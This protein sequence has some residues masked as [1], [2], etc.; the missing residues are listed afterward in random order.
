MVWMFCAF[1]CSNIILTDSLLVA[2]VCCEYKYC[3]VRTD[4]RCTQEGDMYYVRSL[5][6]GCMVC[7]C[8]GSVFHLYSKCAPCNRCPWGKTL[9]HT[10]SLVMANVIRVW[11]RKRRG[12]LS[13]HSFQVHGDVVL[14]H[15]R[16]PLISLFANTIAVGR[17]SCKQVLANAVMVV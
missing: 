10:Q 8:F 9:V 7:A 2:S 11:K 14:E 1:Y 12:H 13:F 15:V 3:F 16:K 5:Q 6:D 4:E 17:V